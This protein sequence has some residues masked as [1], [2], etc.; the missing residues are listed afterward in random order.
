MQCVIVC[1]GKGTRMRPLTD[2]CPKPLIP[3]CGKPILAHIVE[4]LP[5]EID[6]LVL[7]VGYMKEQVIA[8]CGDTFLGKRVVY[9]V[10]ENHAGGTGDALLCAR[11]VLKGTFLFMYG[12]DIHGK[13]TLARAVLSNGAILGTYSE[14]PERYGVL[15]PNEDGTLAAILEKPQNP[16][17]NLINIG[18]FVIH[19]AIFTYDVPKSPSGE[20][21][22]TDMLTAYA[23]DYPVKIFEQDLWLPLGCPEDIPK[24]EAILKDGV[25]IESGV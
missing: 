11:D 20:L 24:A 16:P 2:T 5:P 3:V 10:Q 18:G 9:R 8:Y 23:K 19:E 13:D 14:T 17:S 7:I 15:V 21:Y 1:A 6:E 22:V 4:A 25:S 12:D